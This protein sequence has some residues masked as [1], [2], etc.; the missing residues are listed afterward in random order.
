MRLSDLKPGQSGTIV[1]MVGNGSLTQRLMEMGAVAGTKIRV[2]RYAPLGDPMEI[3]L[4]SYRLSIRKSEASAV[5]V[6]V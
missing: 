3:E 4:H 1:R 6:E 5:E 2:I